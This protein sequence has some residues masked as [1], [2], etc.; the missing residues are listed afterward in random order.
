MDGKAVADAMD[1]LHRNTSLG[2][3]LMALSHLGPY[4]CPICRQGLGLSTAGA[5][6][7]IATEH[8]ITCWTIEKNEG[9][10]LHVTCTACNI[11]FDSGTNSRDWRD[12]CWHI[13]SD[14]EHHLAVSRL[15]AIPNPPSGI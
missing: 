15:T 3:M 4:Q 5:M 7:H 13:M 11:Q 2:D 6:A 8:G 10:H 12:L 9:R 1:Y 14:I